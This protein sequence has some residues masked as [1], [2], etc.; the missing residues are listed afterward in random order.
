M[1]SSIPIGAFSEEQVSRLTGLSRS[2]LS[3]WRRQGFVKPSYEVSRD[4]RK[5]YNFIYS[6]KDLLTLRVVNQLRNAHGVPLSEL[7]KVAS[8][9]KTMGYEDFAAKKLWV[10]NKRVVFKEPKSEK[11]REISSK[12]FAADIPLDVVISDARADIKKINS[13]GAEHF[14][15]LEK[16]RQVVSSSQVF[17]QTRIPVSVVIKYIQAGK[18]NSDIIANFPTLNQKDID[19]ARSMANKQAA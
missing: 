5:S 15:K 9:L 19:L 8:E 14:G 13:R 6:F 17:S 7:R 2:Q 1:S 10:W 16:R 4:R 12:Q 11:F 18:K 3:S